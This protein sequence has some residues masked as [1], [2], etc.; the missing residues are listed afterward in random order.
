LLTYQPV[1][2][3]GTAEPESSAV[4]E[5]A[6]AAAAITSRYQN[7]RFRVTGSTELKPEPA[8]EPSEGMFCSGLICPDS[9]AG[10]GPGIPAFIGLWQVTF[11][12]LVTGA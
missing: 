8:R 5:A 11:S 10:D 1:L 3:L 4:A 7:R 2:V 9:P 6:A 12:V